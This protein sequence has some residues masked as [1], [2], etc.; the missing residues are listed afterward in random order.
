MRTPDSLQRSNGGGRFHYSL[1]AGL[2]L[3]AEPAAPSHPL[4]LGGSHRPDGSGA[5]Q[6]GV[7]ELGLLVDRLAPS[8]DEE[9]DTLGDPRKAEVIVA[10]NRYGPTGT[11]NLLF[12][13]ECGRFEPWEFPSIVHLN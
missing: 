11:V 12:K 7:R 3:A 5:S 9:G 6:A 4:P 2:Q 10:K 1:F 13:E 8:R